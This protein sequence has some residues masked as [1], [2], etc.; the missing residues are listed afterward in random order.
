MRLYHFTKL[1]TAI[2]FILPHRRLRISRFTNLNDPFELL[3]T[4]MKGQDG[5]NLSAYM[6]H[7]WGGTIGLVSMV[8]HWKSPV[9]WGHYAENHAG[10]CLGFDVSD[11]GAVEVEYVVD[12]REF[13]LD[14][15]KPNRGI[16]EEILRKMIS[17]KYAQWSYEE[18]WRIFHDIKKPMEDGFC[19]W[20]FGSSLRLREVILG[21]R[22]KESMELIA[23]IVGEPGFDVK[24]IRAKA[25]LQKFEIVQA[26][27]LP[28]VIV[29][30]SARG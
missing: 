17:T 1:D 3:S 23:K 8:R 10:V 18:E 9:M 30:G 27:R 13:Q 11:E 24:V 16:T 12:R 19:Y 5:R 26:R 4:Y 28:P 14:K 15:T 2:N 20:D 6:H 29:N 7:H 22:C 25:S 21:V